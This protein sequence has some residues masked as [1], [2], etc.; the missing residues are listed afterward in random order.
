MD[1]GGPAHVGL[2]SEGLE[3][4]EWATAAV[5]CLGVDAEDGERGAGRADVDAARLRA[6]E[7][8]GEVGGVGFEGLAEG[9]DELLELRDGGLVAGLGLDGDG[10]GL[11][12]GCSEGCFI[13][14]IDLLV[15]CA[16]SGRDGLGGDGYRRKRGQQDRHWEELGGDSHGGILAQE[17]CGWR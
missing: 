12:E 8:E 5:G 6:G 7:E 2:A 15:E 17:S 16:G 9:G 10:P 11:L 4:E 13:A 1:D 14:G 3:P